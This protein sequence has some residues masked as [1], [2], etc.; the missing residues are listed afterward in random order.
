MSQVFKPATSGS[1]P[2]SVATQYQTDNGTAVPALN[3]LLVKGKEST[4]DNT[5]GIIVK[6]GVVGTGTANEVD[7]TITN[8]MSGAVT[9]TN[10]TP[11]EIIS[12]FALGG[13][14]ATYAFEI[15]AVAINTTDSTG[16]SAKSFGTLRTDGTDAFVVGSQD[17]FEDIDTGMETVGIE[18][19]FSGNAFSIEVTGI[20]GKTIKWVAVATYVKVSA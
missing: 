11:T 18:I 2:P 19:I 7:V 15:T 17:N 1:L 16:W 13:V 9:T 8:R 3:I 5:N 12:P 14:D 10:A 6:G 20:A 4:E